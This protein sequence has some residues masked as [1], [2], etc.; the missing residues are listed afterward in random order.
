MFNQYIYDSNHPSGKFIGDGKY[1]KKEDSNKIN[2]KG[3]KVGYYEKTFLSNNEI[4]PKKGTR[5][6]SKY[7]SMIATKRHNDN[8][9]VCKFSKKIKGLPNKGFY[10]WNEQ[11]LKNLGADLGLKDRKNMDKQTLCDKLQ[12]F[13]Y[14]NDKPI[15]SEWYKIEPTKKNDIPNLYIMKPELKKIYNTDSRRGFKNKYKYKRGLDRERF[16]DEKLGYEEDAQIEIF[17]QED[18]PDEI[19]IEEKPEP[20]K[21]KSVGRPIGTTTKKKPLLEPH[22]KQIGKDITVSFDG[23][24]SN[25]E[26]VKILT[27]NK[28]DE[29]KEEPIKITKKTQDFDEFLK[30]A[31]TKTKSKTK[32]KPEP[33]P[34]EDEEEED[35][36]FLNALRALP[37][38]E[39]QTMLMEKK[40][41]SNKTEEDLLDIRDLKKVIKEKK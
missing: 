39:L 24:I 40:I 3:K 34:E 25:K 4:M 33:E 13:S 20:I 17:K 35:V 12:A 23:N 18:E 29:I 9:P 10:G 2:D 32:P 15:E 31:Q 36:E 22:K 14:G 26:A 27:E 8:P 5:E 19:E 41:I 16:E 28:K 21:K 7:M 30:L 11:A 37:L 38:E 6:R 1:I